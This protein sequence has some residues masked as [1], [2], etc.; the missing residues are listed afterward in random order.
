[1]DRTAWAPTRR[2]SAVIAVFQ[3]VKTCG[4]HAEEPVADGTGEACHIER[5]I[6]FLVFEVLEAIAYGVF[7]ERGNPQTLHRALDARLLHDPPLYQFSFLPG[8]SAVYYL[9][10]LAHQLLYDSELRLYAGVIYELYTKALRYYGQ[11]AKPP[12]FP[13]SGIVMGFLQ[14]TQVSESPRH[15]VPVTLHISLPWYGGTNDIG[16]VSRHTRFLCYANNHVSYN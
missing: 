2:P 14:H 12:P 6:V 1:M 16:D 11:C 15:L 4:I 10:G 3:R 13:C 9:V 5:V 7:R 8:I